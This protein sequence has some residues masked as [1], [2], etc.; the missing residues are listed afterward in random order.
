MGLFG[1]SQAVVVVDNEQVV[2]I[3]T[4]IDLIDYLAAH[5]K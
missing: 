2:G 1:S 3:L 5:M 4:K